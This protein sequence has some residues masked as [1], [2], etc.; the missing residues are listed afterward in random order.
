MK[1][2]VGVTDRY[3]L[4]ETELLDSL[5]QGS[6]LHLPGSATV[7]KVLCTACTLR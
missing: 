7:V 1:R 6:N 3:V 2:Y 5:Q 4:P